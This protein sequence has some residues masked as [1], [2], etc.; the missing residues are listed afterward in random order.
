[1]LNDCAYMKVAGRRVGHVRRLVFVLAK[2]AGRGNLAR[3]FL[4]SLL[5]GCGTMTWP[6]GTSHVVYSTNGQGVETLEIHD[7]KDRSGFS[8]TINRPDGSTLTIESTDVN[9]STAQAQ[10]LTAQQQ[11]LNTL[12]ELVKQLAQRK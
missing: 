2:F 12:A 1:M 6:N 4:C 10:V 7:G 9:G 5:T 11:T 8:T 3:L